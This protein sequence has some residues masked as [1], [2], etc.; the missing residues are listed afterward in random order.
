MEYVPD[1]SITGYCDA[2][3]LSIPERLELLMRVC[4]GVQHAHQKAII[5]H[6]LKP[7]N[8]LVVDFDGK[9]TPRIID[10]GIATV[11][12]QLFWGEEHLTGPG[13]MVG[14]PGYMSP[15]QADPMIEDVDTRTDGCSLAVIL[16][17]LL[18]GFLPFDTK[19]WR[20]QLLH[21]ILPPIAGR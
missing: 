11:L 5:L 14:T 21:Q 20:K 17:E 18:T 16:Y 13:G 1:L 3:K 12:S 9:S 2:K 15:E 6:D 4:G 10:F 7:A 19:E 8:I